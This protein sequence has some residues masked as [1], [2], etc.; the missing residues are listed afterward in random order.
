MIR[1]L[2]LIIIASIYILG[3]IGFFFPIIYADFYINKLISLKWVDYFN[4]NLEIG[5][6]IRV[7]FQA[8]GLGMIMSSVLAFFILFYSA[9][10]GEKWGIIALIIVGLIGGFGEIL[11][12]IF[13]F[14]III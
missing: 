2:A 4:S 6:L 10:K 3:V 7:L 1:I 5:T 11:L 12:E 8:N 14:K 9:K 13:L